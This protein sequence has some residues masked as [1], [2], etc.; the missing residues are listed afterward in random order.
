MQQTH[1]N[2][3]EPPCGFDRLALDVAKGVSAIEWRK[4]LLAQSGQGRLSHDGTAERTRGLGIDA[5]GNSPAELDAWMRMEIA[6]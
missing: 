1:G 6:K 5:Q 4:K 3:S 2:P